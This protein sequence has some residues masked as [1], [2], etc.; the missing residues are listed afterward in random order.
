[1]GQ[2]QAASQSNNNIMALKL[3]YT[4][5]TPLVLGINLYVQARI[6]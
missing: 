1:M 3:K 4:K 6:L 2:K 5:L